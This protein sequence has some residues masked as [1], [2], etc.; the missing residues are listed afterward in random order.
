M[1]A[2]GE[3]VVLEARNVCQHF[4]FRGRPG[5]RAEW[6]EVVSGVSFRLRRGETLAIVGESGAGKSTLAR[7]LLQMPRPT[8]GEVLLH[9][10]DL[11]RLRGRQ[12][13]E[14]W[15]HI[16][17]IFQDPVGSLDP[18]WRV[19]SIVEEPLI[20][21]G[22]GHAAARKRRVD[23]VLEAV[24]LPGAAYARRRRGELS[25]GEC[26]RVAIARALAADPSVIIC[27]EAVSSLD[28]LSRAEILHLLNGL[29]SSA[30]ISC[31]FI[32]HDLTVV[33]HTSDRVAVMYAG[34]L[35]EL[36]PADSLYERAAHPYTSNLLDTLA[37][38]D[39]GAP[40]L[41]DTD[42]P[43]SSTSSSG[44]CRFREHCPRARDRC[45]AETPRL[46]PVGND[47]LVACHF[48][49]RVESVSRPPI[50]R[51]PAVNVPKTLSA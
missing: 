33:K 12:L 17:M 43:A 24:G 29:S 32:S 31:L 1:S 50:A 5:S 9:D 39:I 49:L 15:R 2:L 25:G 36:G 35:V 41:R 34:Q 10:C 47:R 30:G 20:G 16:Q 11:T 38:A 48:P 45:A 7:C 40:A 6:L 23:E 37:T 46:Q 21:Y 28:A 19:S 14:K 3:S 18:K 13:R 51:Y 44:G 27:D 42:E 8:S 4:P 26:Q 22:L